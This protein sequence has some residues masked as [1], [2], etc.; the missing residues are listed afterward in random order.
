MNIDQYG[1]DEDIDHLLLECKACHLPLTLEKKKVI[2]PSFGFSTDSKIKKAGSRFPMT[3]AKTE[4]FYV[5]DRMNIENQ[6]LDLEGV[7]IQY[8][9]SERDRLATKNMNDFYVCESCGYAITDIHFHG[10]VKNEKH[11][12]ADGYNCGN[13]LLKKYEIGY[14][15]ETDV[16]HIRFTYPDIREYDEAVSILNGLLEG[17][18]HTLNIDRQDISGAVKY[19]YNTLT[20][21]NNY[22]LVL[23][24]KTPGGSGYVKQ[25]SNQNTMIKVFENTL[26]LMK[27]CDCG[28]EDMDTACYSCLMN[29][30]NQY[31]HW[32]L[33]RGY[34]VN[35]LE[36][37]LNNKQFKENISNSGWIE[38]KRYIKNEDIKE[39]ISWLET[40][41]DVNPIVG[42]E[43]ESNNYADAE[44]V[45][46]DKKL[47]ILMP[48]QKQYESTIK[49]LGYR[50]IDFSKEQL[51]PI[52][53]MIME[54]IN[55]N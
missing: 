51:I 30:Y 14:T 42:Y 50:T 12:K 37:I 43:F 13:T 26:K 16:M 10:N 45:W 1:T 8:G 2:I 9:Y 28:G 5:G 29:Y 11:V 38:I 44:L 23:F 20:G 27:N 49:E 15:F 41:I 24:D 34:V 21:Q 6:K 52:R 7:D 39:L 53:E 31:Y 46:E 35:F 17:I 55:G 40:K 47:A 4:I 48:S 54:I 19:R 22:Q 32:A 25:L 33:K 3:E 18:S 36:K